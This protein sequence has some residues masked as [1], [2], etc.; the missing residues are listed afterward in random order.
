MR[1]LFYPWTM[2]ILAFAIVMPAMLWLSF[3]ALEVDRMERSAHLAKRLDNDVALALWRMDAVLAPVLAEEAARPSAASKTRDWTPRSPYVLLAFVCDEKGEITSPDTV[4]SSVAD[5][6]C[7]ITPELAAKRLDEFRSQVTRSKLLTM[8]PEHYLPSV[9]QT[10][11]PAPAIRKDE[12]RN[13]FSYLQRSI[14]R[15]HFR[16]IQWR[17]GDSLPQF[18]YEERAGLES[19]FVHRTTLFNGYQSL[20]STEI[21]LAGLESQKSPNP[22]SAPAEP[23][24]VRE[25]MKM[26]VWLGDRLILARRVQQG[27]AVSVEGAWLDW[28]A[29]RERLLQETRDLAMQADLVPITSASGPQKNSLATIP[30]RLDARPLAS[31]RPGWSSL[32]FALSLAWLSVILALVVASV[33]LG[34]M[35]QLSERRAA[36]V[37]AVT[38]E[39]RTPLTTFRM[40][41]EMLAHDMVTNPVQ[42]REYL[43]TLQSESDRLS[44]LV[45]NVLMYAKIER[46][47]KRRS[48]LPTS[49]GRLLRN[50]TTRLERRA[51]IAGLQLRV[52]CADQIAS[53]SVETDPTIV[54]QILFNLVDNSCKYATAGEPKTIVVSAKNE[55]RLIRIGVRDH[56]PGLS[57]SARRLLFAPFCRSKADGAN[58][59][60]GVGLGLALCYR[61]AQ[62]IEGRLE[63]YP[64]RPGVEFILT[65]KQDE[66]SI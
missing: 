56:G 58:Q 31:A 39:L 8:L 63:C 11:G 16:P 60:P 20:T 40:Y 7:H 57:A 43:D 53:A 41:A 22:V 18:D 35:Y 9:R 19:D 32:Q 28:Q 36:F 47:L 1:R 65:V 51:A 14:S 2:F 55:G 62:E 13:D 33:L 61:L 6:V 12:T 49:V 37:S 21:K 66:K 10:P 46:G 30:A 59:A 42:R 4:K 17:A 64:R 23:Q 38:H 50:A 3:T 26:A 25:G 15:T 24:L 54:E 5:E 27:S 45:E 44:H 34:G 52:D 29:I 48:L